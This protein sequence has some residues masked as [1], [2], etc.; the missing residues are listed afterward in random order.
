MQ[1][2]EPDRPGPEDE[3]AVGRLRPGA[4]REG[5]ARE[6]RLSQMKSD[7]VANVSH[8]LRTPVTAILSAAET[9]D[10]AL[11]K[12]PDRAV[13]LWLTHSLARAERRT[14]P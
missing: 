1:H 3:R 4:T 5:A 12:D 14:T 8:E 6:L 11:E 2:R 10:M 13:S 9:L 7:F